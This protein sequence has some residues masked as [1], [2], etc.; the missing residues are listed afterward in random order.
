[1]SNT[2]MLLDDERAA[3]PR[4][5]LRA[6]DDSSESLVPVYLKEMG[7]RSM[8]DKAREVELA[9]AILE[10]KTRL[11]EL[12]LKLSKKD[13]ERLVDA[14]TD[15]LEEPRTWDSDAIDRFVDRVKTIGAESVDR[16]WHVELRAAR[17]RLESARSALIEANLRLVVHIAKQFAN[18]GVP[19]LDLIQEGNIGLM[20]AV[21]K[22][23]F[24]RGNKFSTYAYWWIKQA[25]DRAIV[26]KGRLIRI[27]VH[28]NEKRRKIARATRALSIE[29]GR[30]PKPEEI[31]ERVL[32]PV[33]QVE[34]VLDL[35]KE[36]QSYDD[37]R[38]DEDGQDLLQTVADPNSDS[39]QRSML[40]RQVKARVER[41][42]S[43]LNGRE[44]TIVRLRFGIGSEG[45]HTLEEI[46]SIV[47]LSR[48]RV[49]Q[50][51]VLALEK[52]GRMGML[53]DL[54]DS[55]GAA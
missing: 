40:A 32:L 23:E 28:L 39:P 5:N 11:A 12:A 34:M 33:D 48:E 52:L 30:N 3:K 7:Q 45:T 16:D 49:R 25:I 44:Q 1:M 36:P 31:A 6:G 21:E 20:R 15:R 18:N 37:A 19:L 50:L 43:A 42:V 17:R 53:D 13:R 9:T 10:A 26:D 38:E 2:V 51:E 4:R 27:P 55:T 29:L 41:A 54:L 47:N 22:F 24:E 46:G 14:E 35:V 8:I